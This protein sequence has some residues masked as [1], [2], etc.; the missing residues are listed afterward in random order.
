MERVALASG[1]ETFELDVDGRT[2]RIM[3]RSADDELARLFDLRGTQAWSDASP[4]TDEDMANVVRRLFES[5]GEKH[6]QIEVVGVAPAAA[7]SFPDDPRISIRTIEPMSFSLPGSPNG[8][9]IAMDDHGDGYLWA[10]GTVRVPL[11]GEGMWWIAN[12][13]IDALEDPPRASRWPRILVLGTTLG[14]PAVQASMETGDWGVGIVWRILDSG[15][16]GD[17]VAVNELTYERVDGWLAILRPIRDQL[18]RSGPTASACSPLG[19]P[20]DGFGRWSAGAASSG[21]GGPARL[22]SRGFSRG[23]GSARRRPGP[24]AR[25]RT[26][27][28]PVGWT[29]KIQTSQAQWLTTSAPS[30]TPAA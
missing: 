20:K 11:G 26:V 18:V 6:E 24:Q 22:G 27:T 16:V 1:E 3:T 10:L 14:G 7:D 13:L 17:V 8:L 9:A 23:A 2:I 28:S 29:R 19:R 4:L 25:A 15:V 12:Q 30:G 21:G 5:A